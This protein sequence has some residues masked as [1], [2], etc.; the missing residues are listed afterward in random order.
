MVLV[1]NWICYCKYLLPSFV[2]LTELHCGRW[3]FWAFF[4]FLGPVDLIEELMSADCEDP[5]IH[6]THLLSSFSVH[7]DRIFPPYT[8]ADYSFNL[9]DNEG[10]CDLFDVQFLNYWHPKMFQKPPTFFFLNGSAAFTLKQPDT[11]S[12]TKRPN[13]CQFTSAFCPQ[14]MQNLKKKNCSFIRLHFCIFTFDMY[15]V[16]DWICWAFWLFIGR[17]AA[18]FQSK[19]EFK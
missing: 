5:K 8:G 10:V 2:L 9:D 13:I 15:A 6:S 18:T 3:R 7:F 14:P 19:D 4:K 16:G 11:I 17:M 1:P 12:K